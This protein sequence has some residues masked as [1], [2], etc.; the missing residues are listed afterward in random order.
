MVVN[1]PVIIL[2]AKSTELFAIVLTLTLRCL[3]TK[4]FRTKIAQSSQAL[5]LLKETPRRNA[6]TAR[7]I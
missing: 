2:F 4:E 7:I 6:A 1:N 5:I 3:Q